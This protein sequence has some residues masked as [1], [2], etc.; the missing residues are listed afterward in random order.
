MS[1]TP[2]QAWP[3][4]IIESWLQAETAVPGRRAAD[5]LRELSEDRGRRYTHSTLSRWSR[6]EQIPEAGTQALMM[7]SALGHVLAKAGIVWAPDDPRYELVARALSLPERD[8]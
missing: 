5:A 8:G 4:N 2:T 3:S 7:E 6:G 1:P